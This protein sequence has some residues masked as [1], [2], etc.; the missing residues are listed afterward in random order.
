M[1]RTAASRR[2]AAAIVVL[3]LAFVATT[4]LPASAQEA[5]TGVVSGTENLAHTD[6]TGS[7]DF[8]LCLE[9][10]D[11]TY[12][13]TTLPG[14]SGTYTALNDAVYQ[15]PVTITIEA[16][17]TYYIGPQATHYES[18]SGDDC[19]VGNL[20]PNGP[21]PATITIEGDDGNGNTFGPCTDT[22]ASFW[23]VNSTLEAEWDATCDVEGNVPPFTGSGTAS[24][25]H[26]FVGDL[27]PCGTPA[28][29]PSPS[30]QH[31]IK[32][33]YEQR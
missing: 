10:T 22:S 33:T 11:T 15:G 13:L 6:T 28:P 23:R 1:T 29:C 30:D 26:T 2:G 14:D 31:Q 21:V 5:G 18:G 17:D 4:A 7:G 12:T 19:T 16:N 32:G 24:S 20:G 3:V 9:V 25:S 8:P 27:T